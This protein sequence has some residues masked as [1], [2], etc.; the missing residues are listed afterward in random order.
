MCTITDHALLRYLERVW[1]IDV[2]GARAEMLTASGAVD[3]AADFGCDTVK[4]GNGGRL[5]LAGQTVVTVLPK[6]GR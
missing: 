6:R 5:R 1:G 3:L 4:L 2:P